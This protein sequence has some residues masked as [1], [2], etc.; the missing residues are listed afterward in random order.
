MSYNTQ[1]YTK[2]GGAETVIGGKLTLSGIIAKGDGTALIAN[3]A[4]STATDVAELKTD[5]NALL[6]K[7][8]ASG[9]MVADS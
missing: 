2:Q 3:Q 9:L 4:V 7:L 8:K 1:N 6:A 5:L